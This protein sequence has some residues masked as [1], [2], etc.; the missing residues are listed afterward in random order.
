V[1]A[2]AAMTV[3]PND[4]LFRT[5]N[6]QMN[7]LKIGRS[8]PLA[9]E[10]RVVAQTRQLVTVRADFRREGGALIADATAQQLLMPLDNWPAEQAAIE[11]AAAGQPI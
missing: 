3:V 10:G 1:L 8:H 5:V 7:F 9:V 6:L 4:R 11:A 2:F